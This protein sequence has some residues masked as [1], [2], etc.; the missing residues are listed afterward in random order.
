M[1]AGHKVVTIVNGPTYYAYDGLQKHGVAIQRDA[2][3]MALDAPDRRPFGNELEAL[4]SQGAEK[5]GEETALGMACDVYRVT[6]GRGR[7]EVW[8]TQNEAR[9]PLRIEIF[10]RK[11]GARKYT[12]YIDW[13]TGLAV[14]ARYFEPE[15]DVELERMKFQEYFERTANEGPIGP[16][17]ILYNDL[18]YRRADKE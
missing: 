12:D 4:L 7:R 5:V 6:D 3:A 11:T 17:P 13:L 1:V 14:P 8:V 9:L 10:D 15:A 16:V 18:L 2:S